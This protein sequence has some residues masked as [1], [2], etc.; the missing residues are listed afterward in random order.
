MKQLPAILFFIPCL[1]FGQKDS[2]LSGAYNWQQPVT[3]KKSISSVVLLEGKVHDFEWMQL[4]ANSIAGKKKIKQTIPANQEQ[5]LIVKSGTVSIHFGDST[6]ILTANS[7]AVLM[8][9]EKYSL[10]NAATTAADFYTMKYRS[11]KP[12]DPQR[13]ETSFVKIWENIPYKPN[14]KGGGRRDFFE[15]PTVMQKRFEIHVT[16]LK[17]GLKSHE[18]HAHRAEEIILIIEGETEMQA[19]NEIVKTT[20][21]GFYYLGSNVVHGIKNIG[22]KASTYFAIQ[23]E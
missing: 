5:L 22:T 7:V 17:E 2:V 6:F 3:I 1:A 11:K 9:G 19:G 10:S 18:P 16:T 21:P 20:A 23:F 14:N 12:A 8:P 13:S 4:A 15:Q